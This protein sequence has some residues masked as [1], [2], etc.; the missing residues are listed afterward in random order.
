MD[1]KQHG[2][3]KFTSPDG[4]VYNG[5]LKDGKESGYA[6]YSFSSGELWHGVWG[7]GQRLEWLN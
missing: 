4:T 5:L 6:E 2:F 1:D 3:G 7:A